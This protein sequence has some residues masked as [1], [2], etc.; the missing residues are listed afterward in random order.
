[1]KLVSRLPIFANPAKKVNPL[2]LNL[3]QLDLRDLQH[4]TLSL[5]LLF[6]VKVLLS[7][8]I[9]NGG[10][11]VVGKVKSGIVGGV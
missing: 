3:L 11:C 1:M 7:I 9:E 2:L 10:G 6:G 5:E 4:I 8:R